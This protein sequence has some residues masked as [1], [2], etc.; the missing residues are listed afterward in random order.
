MACSSS[1]RDGAS[2][3]AR[4]A[5]AEL[6][7]ELVFQIAS[8]VAT[9]QDLM[10]LART[11][12]SWH[13]V[14]DTDSHWR[15][16]ALLRFPRLAS[17]A[18]LGSIAKPAGWRNLY[19]DQLAID[20]PEV[21]HPAPLPPKL[22]DFL[23]TIEMRH[24]TQNHPQFS[25]SGPLL[26]CDGPCGPYCRLWDS[27]NPPAFVA[28]L[29]SGALDASEWGLRILVSR[30]TPRGPHTIELYHAGGA[31]LVELG[32]PQ[33]HAGEV[34]ADWTDP[35]LAY[36]PAPAPLAPHCSAHDRRDEIIDLLGGGAVG[37]DP[38]PPLVV[39]T[40]I[41]LRGGDSGFF[42]ELLGKAWDEG[43]TMGTQQLVTYLAH[44]SPL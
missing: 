18:K 9:I 25:W 8:H 44:L 21:R 33:G 7:V 16:L 39:R 2:A 35:Y 30:A 12:R 4:P 5:I 34:H 38:M 31:E 11:C 15:R 14:S 36:S 26:E 23:F 27:S 32:V 6:P 1:K 28:A 41:K 20:F 29:C 10:R 40:F 37:G 17:I 43:I 42:D 22:E 19:R 24:Q 3:D 13:T